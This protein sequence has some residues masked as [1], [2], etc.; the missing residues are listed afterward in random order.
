MP[1]D[2]AWAAPPAEIRDNHVGLQQELHAQHMWNSPMSARNAINAHLLSIGEPPLPHPLP[3][4]FPDPNADPI[5]LLEAALSERDEQIS[6]LYAEAKA[7]QSQL[8]A[9]LMRISELEAKSGL[10]SEYLF[11]DVELST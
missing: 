5:A 3:P 11:K 1:I 8:E 9:A 6:G 10:V 4:H 7:W 2:V